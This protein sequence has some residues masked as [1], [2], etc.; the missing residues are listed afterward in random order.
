MYINIT[1]TIPDIIHRTAFYLKTLRFGDC[2]LSP[3]SVK[4]AQMG[5]IELVS[6][7]GHQQQHQHQIGPI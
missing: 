1:I 7:S 5:Q 6:V 3:S 4:P 2:T